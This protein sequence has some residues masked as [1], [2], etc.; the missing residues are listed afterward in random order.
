MVVILAMEKE[1]RL[2][3]YTGGGGGDIGGGCRGGV[4]GLGKVVEMEKGIEVG[5]W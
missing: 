5:G 4:I 2:E 3:G 1:A